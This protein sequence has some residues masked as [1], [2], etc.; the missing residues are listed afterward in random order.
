MFVTGTPTWAALSAGGIRKLVLP[1][2]VREVVIAADPDPV[3]IIAAHSAARR[4]L[5]EVRRVSICRPPLD[6]D[7]NDL[8]RA[9]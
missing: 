1:E 6:C 2:C 8:A 9:S 7:F 5:H 4:W 3:G